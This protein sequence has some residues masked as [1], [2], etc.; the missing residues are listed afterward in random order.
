MGG[1]AQRGTDVITVCVSWLH[2][3]GY[4]EYLR[5]EVQRIVNNKIIFRS[6]ERFE[7]YRG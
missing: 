6:C 1:E 3:L 2:A 5:G 7:D 4:D